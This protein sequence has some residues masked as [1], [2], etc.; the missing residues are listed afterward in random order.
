MSERIEPTQPPRRSEHSPREGVPVPTLNGQPSEH[1]RKH[2]S[3]YHADC[4]IDAM[5]RSLNAVDTVE[6]NREM[7]AAE[8][9]ALLSVRDALLEAVAT[10]REIGEKVLASNQKLDEDI[11]TAAQH[12][13]QDA[14]ELKAQLRVIQGEAA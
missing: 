13:H 3:D 2:P 14:R 4:A 7:K 5:G 11:Q 1:W 12:L 8:T 10:A 9:H 6:K